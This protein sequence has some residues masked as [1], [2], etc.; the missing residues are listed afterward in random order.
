MACVIVT[1][2]V[3]KV[4]VATVLVFTVVAWESGHLGGQHPGRRRRR[5]AR[6]ID[7]ETRVGGE[8]REEAEVAYKQ[9]PSE[10]KPEPEAC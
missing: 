5:M 8:G 10:S 7:A 1:V 6:K 2:I 3:S 4:V 9:P